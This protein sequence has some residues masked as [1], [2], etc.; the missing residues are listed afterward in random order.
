MG[1]ASLLG[2]ARHRLGYRRDMETVTIVEWLFVIAMFATCL[3]TFHYWDMDA[4]LDNSIIF[5]KSV[6]HGQ[7]FDFYNIAPQKIQTGWGPNYEIPAYI[8]VALWNIPCLIMDYFGDFNYLE[9]SGCI[10]WNRLFILAFIIS[11]AIVIYKICKHNGLNHKRSLFG[12]Y[13]FLS[14]INLLMFTMVLTQFEIVAVFFMLLGLY[15]YLQNRTG[16]FILFFAIAIPLKMFAI[17]IF[18][19][20]L[21]LQEKNILRLAAK[22]FC[23]MSVQIVCKLLFMNSVVYQAAT[24]SNTQN[25]IKSLLGSAIAFGGLKIPAF[26][27]FL[28]IVYLFCYFTKLDAESVYAKKMFLYIPL[29]IFS[30]LF[31]LAPTNTYWIVILLPFMAI[32]MMVSPDR[33]VPNLILDIFI[34]FSYVFY[35]FF[36]NGAFSVIYETSKH[37]YVSSLISVQN[38]KYQGISGLV[39]RLFPL[40]LSPAFFALFVAGLIAFLIINYPKDTVGIGNLQPVPM[41]IVWAKHFVCLALVLLLI[42]GLVQETNIPEISTIGHGSQVMSE[43]IMSSQTTISQ[44][45]RFSEDRELEEMILKF[46]NKAGDR[47]NMG[48]ITVTIAD[49]KGHIIFKEEKG[50]SLIASEKNHLI[51]LRGAKVRANEEYTISFTGHPDQLKRPIYLFVT[52]ELIYQDYPVLVNGAPQNYN[53]YMEI[54]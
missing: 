9:S 36:Q 20:L 44:K 14:S 24:G 10:L 46:N 42:Y 18:V 17:F 8:L 33:L 52:K 5:V 49:E 1:I 45:V 32:M 7:F 41:F 2:R 38:P 30:M 40:N 31:I 28:A 54:R 34:S 39:L 53:L 19:P 51:D 50:T 13:L 23:G 37:T 22:L 16:L 47:E 4:I 48:Y 43:S 35:R 11:T 15:M 12:A 21:L 3:V 6:Y 26:I 25:M 29:A 27:L